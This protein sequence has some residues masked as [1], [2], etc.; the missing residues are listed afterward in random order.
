M[1]DTKNMSAKGGSAFGGKRKYIIS[2]ILIVVIFGLSFS[3]LNL[4]EVSAKPLLDSIFGTDSNQPAEF[5]PNLTIPGSI[6]KRGETLTIDTTD[7]EGNYISG[8]LAGEYIAALYK[9]FVGIAGIIAVLMIAIGGF[10]WLF[11]G[12]SPDKIN[13]A[14]ETIFGAIMGLMLALGSYVIL[15]TIN[16]QLVDFK[17]A[18]PIV[19]KASITEVK[20][21]SLAKFEAANAK[22]F[23]GNCGFSFN[24]NI[25]ALD[26]ERGCV[27]TR[28]ESPDKVCIKDGF[29]SHSCKGNLR[30]TTLG[31][32]DPKWADEEFIVRNILSDEKFDCGNV[33]IAD[34]Q[35]GSSRHIGSSC[36]QDNE[37]ESYCVIENG[38]DIVEPFPNGDFEEYKKVNSYCG[39]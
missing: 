33:Y 17:L 13:A 15:Y 4:Q 3:F 32:T 34:T 25:S 24:L 28:C 36:A 30:L 6:F 29:S 27:F 7:N 12:G 11:S 20:Y 16:P 5:T 19:E 23:Y 1:N 37:S 9:F 31:N 21:C 26:D 39:N 18:I 22:D 14:K 10:I 2:L 8:N 35:D 38:L